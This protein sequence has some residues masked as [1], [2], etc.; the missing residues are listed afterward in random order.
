MLTGMIMHILVIDANTAQ[1]NQLAAKYNLSP[2]GHYYA[3]VLQQISPEDEYS[4][5]QPSEQ[6]DGGITSV[7]WSS[8]DG[9]VWT[10]SPLNIYHD[11]IAIKRQLKLG[12]HSLKLGKTSFGSCWGLQI[13]VTLLGGKVHRNPNGLEFGVARNI[14]KTEKGINH[15]LLHGRPQI[16]SAL[17]VHYDE[18]LTLPDHSQL[19]ASNPHSQVQAIAYHHAGLDVWAVQYHP[20]F[21]LSHMAK[22]I[23][24]LSADLLDLHFFEN[25]DS[26]E[27]TADDWQR[28][29]QHPHAKALKFRYGI[30][31][32]VAKVSQHRRE[33][34]NWLQFVRNKTEAKP[35]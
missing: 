19:L 25:Q 10:G 31:D 5:L 33:L 15:P 17:A 20:E 1:G 16:Y 2:Y 12:E 34:E 28:L 23:H 26:L 4:V 7:D 9:V 6:E 27:V 32:E 8:I 21:D 13:L 18:I 30:D 22:L 3:D 29:Y 35:H 11:N 14:A 24:R